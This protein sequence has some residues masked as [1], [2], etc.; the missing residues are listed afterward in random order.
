MSEICEA[1]SCTPDIA[2][3]QDLALVSAILDYRAACMARDAF[4]DPKEGFKTFEA[5]PELLKTLARMGRA[6]RGLPLDAPDME[7]EGMRIAKAQA[8]EEGSAAR[9]G[10]K[11]EERDHREGDN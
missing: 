5:H 8:G 1:F 2:L 10:T 6:Q 7:R 3:R 4:N 11:Q 9:T